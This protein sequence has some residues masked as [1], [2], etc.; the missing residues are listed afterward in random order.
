MYI[1]HQKLIHLPV[2][3]ESGTKL[4]HVYDLE[5]D[6]ETHQIR[7]YMVGPR[8]IG[9]ETYLITPAQIKSI[10]EEKMIVE[11]TITK[12]PEEMKKSRIGPVI[13]TMPE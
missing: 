10:T 12:A 13:D 9:K 6:I 4:G 3:T 2:V 8:F 11:D 7:K 5:I 1:N